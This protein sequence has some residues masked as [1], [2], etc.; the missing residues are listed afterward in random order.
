MQNGIMMDKDIHALMPEARVALAMCPFNVVAVAPGDYR[1]MSA[2]HWTL[3]ASEAGR[4]LARLLGAND[5][6]ATVCRDM[7]PVMNGK[8]IVNLHNAVSAL[9]GLEMKDEYGQRWTRVLIAQCYAEAM[10]VYRAHHMKYTTSFPVPLWLLRYLL[11]LPNVLFRPLWA[12]VAR[13]VPGA[14]SSMYDDFQHK[15]QT[16]IDY[17]QGAIIQLAEKK[18]IDVPV[19]RRLYAAV[20]YYEAQ[21][22]GIVRR[23]PETLFAPVEAS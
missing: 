22:L 18:G 8:L 6:A 13:A 23:T 12:L 21:R 7:G 15:R 4:L 16:E 20:K 3:D 17:F 11:L 10:A 9:S 5:V 14:R 2:G 1:P 19:C